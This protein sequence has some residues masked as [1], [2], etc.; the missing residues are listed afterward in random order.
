MPSALKDYW[1]PVI[2]LY[3]QVMDHCRFNGDFPKSEVWCQVKCLL[4]G[5]YSLQ[6][7][8]ARDESWCW[9][10]R[11]SVRGIHGLEK[12]Y[13]HSNII[14]ECCVR[15]N[16]DDRL[17]FGFVLLSFS[18]TSNELLLFLNATW[19]ECTTS[20]QQPLR[21][22]KMACPPCDAWLNQRER[23]L[24]SLK[25]LFAEK[26]KCPWVIVEPLD[27]IYSC[28]DSFEISIFQLKKV[29]SDKVELMGST[30]HWDKPWHILDE[31]LVHLL[32]IASGIWAPCNNFSPHTDPL[33]IWYQQWHAAVD[34]EP[35]YFQQR[36]YECVKELPRMVKPI[37]IN[38]CT[39]IWLSPRSQQWSLM[40]PWMF[41]QYSSS[42]HI[43]LLQ[44]NLL[45]SIVFWKWPVQLVH[46]RW[47]LPICSDQVPVHLE[48]IF[49]RNVEIEY[50]Q[51]HSMVSQLI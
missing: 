45:F 46:L 21:G 3:H 27:D 44:D 38:I 20:F 16:P 24:V 47:V 22:K 19:T 10:E 31:V 26:P 43:G 29:S 6:L 14:P 9:G 35:F 28:V 2:G 41:W 11:E 13:I 42:H 32:G 51:L 17:H 23:L 7:Q 30:V 49:P 8:E 25:L 39:K 34:S 33:H 1:E 4:I 36:Y 37:N 5:G 18:G 15:Y 40:S 48:S 50:Q 12:W